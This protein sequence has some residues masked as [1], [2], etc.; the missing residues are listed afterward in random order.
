[1]PIRSPFF[2]AVLALLLAGCSGLLLRPAAP[3]PLPPGVQV[4]AGAL[5]SS[6]G[7]TLAYRLFRPRGMPLHDLV[8]L[9]HGFLRSQ[10][11]M[12][13]LAAS[14]AASGTPVATLDLCNMHPWDGGHAQNAQDMI[15]LARALG[16]GRVVYAGFSA[17]GL[18][19]VLAGRMDPSAVGIVTLD[20]VETQGLGVRAATGLDIPL[21]ALAGEPTNC[22]ARGNGRAVLAAADQARV[23]PIAGAGHCDFEA[24]TDA[25]CELVCQDPDAGA[26]ERGSDDRLRRRI[27]AAATAAVDALLGGDPLVWPGAEGTTRLAT[28]A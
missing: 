18:A 16:A 5:Q 20:L 27:I 21:L 14:I 12:R 7:C 26:P 28:G 8:V 17:G 24:P 4:T 22:N 23:A 9:A 19:A 25:L 11:R 10:E 1:M 13:D 6:T 15:A 3:P 2:A